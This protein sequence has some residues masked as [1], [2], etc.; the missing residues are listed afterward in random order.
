M[1]GGVKGSTPTNCRCLRCRLV[2]GQSR[3]WRGGASSISCTNNK[4]EKRLQYPAIAAITTTMVHSSNQRR[5]AHEQNSHGKTCIINT[6][7]SGG[8]NSG[9]WWPSQR[10]YINTPIASQRIEH[11]MYKNISREGSRCR[12]TSMETR[13]SVEGGNN[14]LGVTVEENR[15]ERGYPSS[16]SKSHASQINLMTNERPLN[17][18]IDSRQ[19]MGNLPVTGL[20]HSAEAIGGRSG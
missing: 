5:K 16:R 11:T 17:T 4:G 3:Q 9:I 10:Q 2:N 1:G 20:A 13:W 15:D 14:N 6:C 7:I 19:V 12:S 18:R 8:S